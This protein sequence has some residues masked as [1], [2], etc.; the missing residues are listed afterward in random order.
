[1]TLLSFA[2]GNAKL[3]KSD[4]G[5]KYASAIMY[6]APHKMS[7]HN[8][9]PFASPGCIDSCLFTSGH[10]AFNS[11]INAR[12]ARTKFFLSDRRS[13]ITQLKKE[14]TSHVV[15]SKKAGRIPCIRL[16]GTSDIAWE[17]IE[18][19]IFTDFSSIQFYDYTKIPARMVRW[20]EGKLP[21]NYHLTFSRS[22]NNDAVCEEILHMGGSV[23]VVFAKK[24]ELPSKFYNR[25]VVNGD[26]TDLRFLDPRGKIIGL[27]AKGRAKKDQTGFVVR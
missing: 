8:M 6:L 10:G 2:E 22:E 26:E 27:Y 9:C 3:S 21:K 15:K 12:L 13:F 19:S 4:S 18:P 20:C 7:G 23:A 1:M 17:V 14:I 16:N 24:G 11:V 25:K 5:G